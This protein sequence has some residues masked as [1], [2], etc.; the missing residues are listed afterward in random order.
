MT[1]VSAG[2]DLDQLLEM[3]RR[4]EVQLARARNEAARLVA[5]AEAAAAAR[6]S[7]VEAELVAAA[8]AL[9]ERIDADRIR[10][11]AEVAAAAAE[12]ATR[13]ETVSPQC[14]EALARLVIERLLGARA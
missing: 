4:L 2:S 5:E 6:D 11:E 9:D 7:A 10:R 14:M 13:Y 3:E 1:A 12:D 8:A